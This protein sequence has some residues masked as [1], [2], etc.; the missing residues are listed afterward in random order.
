MAVQR[1]EI[2]WETELPKETWQHIIKH[3]T[4]WPV[5]NDNGIA[6]ASRRLNIRWRQQHRELWLEDFRHMIVQMRNCPFIGPGQELFHMDEYLLNTRADINDVLDTGHLFD[7]LAEAH[8]N[9]VDL[10][11]QIE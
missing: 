11:A 4:I 8:Y 3:F 1:A 7:L 5:C 6:S 10:L 2:D 9:A